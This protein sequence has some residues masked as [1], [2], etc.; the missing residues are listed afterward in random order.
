MKFTI[1]ATLDKIIVNKNNIDETMKTIEKQFRKFNYAN[2]EI[3]NIQDGEKELSGPRLSYKYCDEFNRLNKDGP[4]YLTVCFKF[5]SLNFDN[6]KTIYYIYSYLEKSIINN[7]YLHIT[8]KKEHDSFEILNNTKYPTTVESSKIIKNKDISDIKLDIL[9][10]LDYTVNSMCYSRDDF[11]KFLNELEI[12]SKYK[13][14][15][16]NIDSYEKKV[17]PFN[18]KKKTE[19]NYKNIDVT[20]VHSFYNV[21]DLINEAKKQKGIQTYILDQKDVEYNLMNTDF[22]NTTLRKYTLLDENMNLYY[23]LEEIN[24]CV[25]EV[26]CCLYLSTAEIPDEQISDFILFSDNQINNNLST[27]KNK[28]Y[29]SDYY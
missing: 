9:D 28:E 7:Q 19:I 2:F 22:S 26:D 17:I 4:L 11:D 6:I 23:I 16:D 24:G 15:I 25:D 29:D 8:V 3:V 20:L 14:I 21:N 1:Q 10:F 13:D 27:N 5:S 12:K 18:F